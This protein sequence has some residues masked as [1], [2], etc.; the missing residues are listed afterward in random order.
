M[1][2]SEARRA[3]VGLIYSSAI[4]KTP[5]ADMMDDFFNEENFIT[6]N[7]ED[8]IFDKSPDD[9]TLAYI[10]NVLSLADEHSSEL[11]GYIGKYAK[12]WKANRISGV[13]LAAMKCAMCEMLYID[14]IPA[15]AS[16]SDAVD[17]VKEYDEEDTASFVNAVLRSF[18]RGEIE[19]NANSDQN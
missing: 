18:I 9:K 4:S 15:G 1:K 8:V 16:V 7:G 19:T 10:K 11:T 2:R 17:I 6:L 13:A 5:A 3:A 14:D 12:G